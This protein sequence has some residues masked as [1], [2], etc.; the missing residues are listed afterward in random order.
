MTKKVFLIAGEKSGDDLGSRLMR[1]LIKANPSIEFCGVGGPLMEASGLKSLFAYETLSVMGFVEVLPKIFELKAKI[2]KTAEEILVTKPDL[3]ITIDLPGF[4]YRVAK[5]LRDKG[6]KGKIFHYVAP[7]VWAYKESRAAKFARVFDRMICILPFEEKYFTKHG[8]Q[9]NYI[10]NP[11]IE[12]S[13]PSK[14]PLR[15]KVSKILVCCGSRIGEIKKLL[16]IFSGALSLLSNRHNFE[17]LILTN[18]A[19]KILISEMLKNANFRYS[20]ATPQDADKI[21]TMA[22][23]DLALTKSGTVTTEI[24]LAGLPMVVAH[25]VNWL[26]YL[27]IK[28]MVKISSICLVN[29]ISKK[30]IVPELI[31]K[32]CQADKIAKALEELIT[33]YEIRKLQIKGSK[34]IFEMLGSKDQEMP[35]EK[36]AKILLSEL[37][38]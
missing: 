4:N 3:V 9:T 22:E 16:P 18:P 25:K 7:T 30:Q 10:G 21:K 6:Y 28:S 26:S 38:L 5:T 29:L 11:V 19:H 32:D 33:N 1:S 34:Q 35:S 20:I 37:S 17:A 14:R 27:I 13:N 36:L 15:K 31:Q 24:A 12:Q 23:C 8:M 2:K